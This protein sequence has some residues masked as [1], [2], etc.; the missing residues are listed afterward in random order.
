MLAECGNAALAGGVRRA[1]ADAWGQS[2]ARTLS[3]QL[4]Q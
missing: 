4:L 3:K 2:R 1:V